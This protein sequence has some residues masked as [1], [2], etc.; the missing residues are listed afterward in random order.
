MQKLNG[1]AVGRIIRTKKVTPESGK[2]YASVTLQLT[3]RSWNGKT[4]SQ[5]VEARCYHDPDAL[6]RDLREGDAA[7][8][9]GDTEAE[10]FDY[11]GRSLAKIVVYGIPRRLDLRAASAAKSR[12]STGDNAGNDDDVPT[13]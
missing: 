7:S 5:R 13:P 6:L 11:N 4:Y 12:P 1:T 9:S 10:P 8:V 2:P 3:P